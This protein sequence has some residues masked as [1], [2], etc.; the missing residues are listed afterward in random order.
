M[1]WYIGIGDDLLRDTRI[2]FP[3]LRNID[4]DYDA[5][6]LIWTDRLYQCEDKYDRI[7][8]NCHGRD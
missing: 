3:F 7:G 2:K 6:D 8:S 4:K 5:S 1:T